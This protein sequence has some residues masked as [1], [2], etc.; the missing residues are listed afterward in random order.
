MMKII[1]FISIKQPFFP[2]HIWEEYVNLF[3]EKPFYGKNIRTQIFADKGR[4]RF[5]LKNSFFC[6]LYFNPVNPRLSVSN[7]DF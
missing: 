5:F 4:H 1:F 2:Y 7:K 3:M 6:I